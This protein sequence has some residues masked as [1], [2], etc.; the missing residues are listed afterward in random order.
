MTEL[1]NHPA[2]QSSLVP[3]ATALIVAAVFFKIR[4]GGLSAAAGFLATVIV[5]GNFAF[6]PLTASRKIVLV[7]AAAP[8]FGAFADLVFRTPRSA[9]AALG[10]LFPASAIWVFWSILSQKGMQEALLLGAG[11][12][13]LMAWLVAFTVAL[14]DDPVRAGAAGVS[15]G[16]GSGITAVIGASA[17]LGQYGMAL[18]AASGAFVLMVMV[19]GRKVAAG[20]TLTLTASVV[21]G[22]VCIGG[23][24]LAQVPWTAAVAIMMVPVLVRIPLPE[25]APVW[26]QCMVATAYGLFMAGIACALA[27]LASRATPA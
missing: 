9:V 4:L 18:G 6:E 8:L 26:L 10:I 24:L 2:I 27:W 16:L 15:L 23:M 14:H 1:L 12:V 25:R 19:L 13:V 3:F 17:L 5:V 21:A 20:A 11:I 22:L 7:G